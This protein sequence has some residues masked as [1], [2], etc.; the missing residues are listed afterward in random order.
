[1]K[2]YI[3]LAGFIIG[4]IGLIGLIV[5]IACPFVYCFMHGCSELNVFFGIGWMLLM[6]FIWIAHYLLGRILYKTANGNISHSK[7]E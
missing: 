3:E 7:Y 1:M 5:N 2:K 6:D 4:M